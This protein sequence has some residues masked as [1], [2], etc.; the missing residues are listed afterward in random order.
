MRPLTHLAS[1]Q[2]AFVCFFIHYIIFFLFESS[3]VLFIFLKLKSVLLEQFY[4]VILLVDTFAVNGF[5]VSLLCVA[6]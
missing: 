5:V 6:A 1:E 3:D 4:Y 2:T